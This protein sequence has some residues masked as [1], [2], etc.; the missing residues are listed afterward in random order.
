MAMTRGHVRWPQWAPPPVPLPAP[1]SHDTARPVGPL[2]SSPRTSPKHC[3][4]AAVTGPGLGR[5]PAGG[6]RRQGALLLLRLLLLLLLLLLRGLGV[7][8]PRMAPT[9]TAPDNADGLGQRRVGDAVR[10]GAHVPA[11]GSSS[12]DLEQWK[13]R[14]QQRQKAH[15]S[16]S[17]TTCK[18]PGCMA[19]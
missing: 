4:L 8:G 9:D 6:R 18:A 3:T 15:G 2:T 13:S 19:G 10:T 11:T 17:D 7:L 12:G 14:H 16:A 1:S 5:R